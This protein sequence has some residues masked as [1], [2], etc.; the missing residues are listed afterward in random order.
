[1]SPASQPRP[2]QRLME[3]L[4]KPVP[5]EPTPEQAAEFERWMAEGDAKARHRQDLRAEAGPSPAGDDS[6]DEADN[7]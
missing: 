4:G 7:Q 2:S 5:A 6:G 1:M 3:A